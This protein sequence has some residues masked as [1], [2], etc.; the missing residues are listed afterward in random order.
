MLYGLYLSAQGAESQ[1]MRQGVLANNLANVG[2]NAFKPDIAVFRS[3]FPYDVAHQ[4]PQRAPD[5]IDLETGGVAL[6]GTIT[7]FSQGSLKPTGKSTDAALLGN[8]FY[9]VKM[10]NETLLTRDG[11]FELDANGQLVHAGTGAPVLDPD[12]S[13]IVIPPEMIDLQIGDGGQI[14]GVGPNGIVLPISQ[15]AVVVPTRLTELQKRGDGMYSTKLP[16]A[17]APP[18]TRVRQGFVE[19]SSADPMQGTLELIEVSRGFES[20]VNMMRMQDEM[21]GRLLQA[22]PRR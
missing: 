1:A 22:I 12:G 8:G 9:Q 15:L 5:T 16:V 21:L 20:N 2:T 14:S 11:S 19:A 4:E 3:Y 18:E 7:D 13:E 10:G 6:E 17:E